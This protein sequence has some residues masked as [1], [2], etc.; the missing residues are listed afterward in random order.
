MI[1][2]FDVAKF[3]H[4]KSGPGLFPGWTLAQVARY[5]IPFFNQNQIRT[6]SIDSI[7]I[8]GAL[9]FGTDPSCSNKIYVVH[10]AIDRNYSIKIFKAFLGML[11]KEYPEVTHI[12]AQRKLGKRTVVFDANRMG[13]IYFNNTI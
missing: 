4:S 12:V 5:L 2:P 8:I 1:T 9:V 10:M 7:K 6:V 13:R 3:L 11:K